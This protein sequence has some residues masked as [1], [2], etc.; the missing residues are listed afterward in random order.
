MG[1][2]HN[3]KDAYIIL[4]VIVLL[5]GLAYMGINHMVNTNEQFEDVGNVIDKWATNSKVVCLIEVHG[6]RYKTND[7]DC[8]DKIIGD[9]VRVTMN[10]NL[11][12]F[13]IKLVNIK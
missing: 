6:E 8:R 13:R 5:I 12:D 4:P 10:K 9:V 3:I 7:I 2:E 11:E 1:K